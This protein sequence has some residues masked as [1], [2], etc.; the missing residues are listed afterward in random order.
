MLR[1]QVAA[2]TDIGIKRRVNQDAILVE[3]AQ[4]DLGTVLLA[5]VADGM[6][7]LDMGEMASAM[8]TDALSGWFEN[9][10]A[11]AI[12]REGSMISFQ[13]FCEE[14]DFLIRKTGSQITQACKS[15]S[16]TTLTA[17]LMCAGNYY[18]VHVGDTRAYLIRDEV[19]QLTK[20]QTYVQRQ[21]DLG[22]LK[23]EEIET[24]PKRNVLLQCVGAN[25]H[26]RPEYSQG[27]Y[28]DRDLILLCSD[29]FRHKIGPQDFLTALSPAEGEGELEAALGEMI[30]T[31]KKRE[32]TDNI[33]AV[34]IRVLREGDNAS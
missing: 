27:G 18:L 19:R 5:G 31:V 15:S 20:D 30:G 17:L 3:E 33:S 6:G 2:K 25:S 16:G 26:V 29:G 34:V 14:M 1:Y 28:K 4:T 32:E 9:N 22:L 21:L 10:L 23:E 7:G 11:A 8:I 13:R 12:A 24:H